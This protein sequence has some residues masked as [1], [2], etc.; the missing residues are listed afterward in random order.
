MTGTN[1]SRKAIQMKT[2]KGNQRKPEKFKNWYR[3]NRI[4]FVKFQNFSNTSNPF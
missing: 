3:V 1:L 2:F 4:V